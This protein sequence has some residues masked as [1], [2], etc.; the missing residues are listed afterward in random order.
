MK[1]NAE[2]QN[3]FWKRKFIETINDEYEQFTI[4]KGSSM[5]LD[6]KNKIHFICMEK[7]LVRQ[8]Y[9]IVIYSLQKPY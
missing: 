9:N 3:Y 5:Q 2:R 4:A 6:Q 8:T 7:I 1:S